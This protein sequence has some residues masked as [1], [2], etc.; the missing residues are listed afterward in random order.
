MSVDVGEVFPILL[1]QQDALVVLAADRFY[2]TR[3]PQ[4]ETKP[5]I[6]FERTGGSEVPTLEAYSSV[7][8][9]TFKL[10]GWSATSQQ[11]A[12]QLRNLA[13][14][15]KA[16]LTTRVG[17][18]WIQAINAVPG[19]EID[20]PQTPLDSSDNPGFASSAEV[21]IFYKRGGT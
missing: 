12:Q 14:A 13:M 1:A 16:T 21:L 10:A 7:F 19:T 6:V 9:A 2:P 4:R 8:W 15:I 11:E 5:A 3:L 17:D 20:E 18:W